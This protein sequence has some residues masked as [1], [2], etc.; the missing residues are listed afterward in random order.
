MNQKRLIKSLTL[1]IP[2]IAWGGYSITK[3]LLNKKKP[4]SEDLMLFS[5]G[6]LQF[7]VLAFVPEKTARSTFFTPFGCKSILNWLLR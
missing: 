5:A 2:A 1:A 7:V 3:D 4:D 6:L